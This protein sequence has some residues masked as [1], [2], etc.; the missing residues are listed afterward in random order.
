MDTLFSHV[1]VVTMDARMSVWLD[2]FVGVTD[3]KISYLGK[4]PP[5]EKPGSIIDGTGMVMMPGLI[6]CHTHLPM[7]LL[8]G[9]ADDLALQTWLGEYIFPREEHLDARAVKAAALLGIAECL[10]F[11]VTSVSDMYYF[12]DAVAEAVA[13]SGIKANLSLAT[14][15]FLGD[16]FDFETYPACR[17]MVALHGKWHGYDSGRIKIDC[18]IHAE[19]TSTYQLWD[20]LAEY[21]INNRLGMHVHLSE[22][23]AEHEECMEKYGLTPAQVLDCHHVFDARTI[24]A[25]CVHLTEDDMRLLAKRGVSAVH[26]PVSNLKLASGCAD[27]M[28]MVRAGMNVCLGTDSAA[29]NNNLDLFEEIKACAL[30]AK[31]KTGD[32]TAVGAEAALMMATV[33]GAR[34]QGREKECGQIAVGMDAELILLDFNQQHLIP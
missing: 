2:A 13:Q 29:S 10:R 17:E 27:V 4:K 11:G 15:M 20:A 33:C 6:N 16:D 31:G 30:M 12:E 1:S 8:R 3:G 9:Y 32:P 19:Y 21:A 25:H 7:A 14:T 22:T 26:C 23:R 18:S 24:A 34:A 5:E 28:G